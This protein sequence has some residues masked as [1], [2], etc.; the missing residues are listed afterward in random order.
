ML[1]LL[2]TFSLQNTIPL[3][4]YNTFFWGDGEPKKYI[5]KSMKKKSPPKYDPTA[6][7]R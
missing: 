4:I 6:A 1:D 2:L 3:F 7:L 5:K